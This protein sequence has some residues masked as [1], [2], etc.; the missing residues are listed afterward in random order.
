MLREG[1]RE[2]EGRRVGVRQK[3]S[4]GERGR[5]EDTKINVS[6]VKCIGGRM[7]KMQEELRVIP[8]A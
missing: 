2:R 4:D 3:Q 1:E 5:E 8:V 6:T 7:R